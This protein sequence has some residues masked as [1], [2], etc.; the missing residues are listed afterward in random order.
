MSTSPFRPSGAAP[1]EGDVAVLT[2]HRQDQLFDQEADDVAPYPEDL[3][4]LPIVPV[5]HDG[6]LIGDV[7]P[8][9]ELDQAA[10]AE[11]SYE[12]EPVDQAPRATVYASLPGMPGRGVVLVTALA[13][14]GTAALDFALTGGLSYFFDL[15]FVVICLV[16]AMAVR[17]HDLFTSGVL[18]PIAFGATIGVIALT[19]PAT[20]VAAGSGVSEV[21]LTGLTS[22][23]GA[24]VFGYGTALITVAGRAAHHRHH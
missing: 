24:L 21:F 22:H 1:P 8:E 7:D 9:A 2:E 5:V 20:F 14:A 12:Y 10:Y 16:A 13:T 11:D 15:T 6:P 18:P 4:V 23:A 17:G 19:S 3:P